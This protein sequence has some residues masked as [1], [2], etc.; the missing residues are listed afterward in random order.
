MTEQTDKQEIAEL[1]QVNAE[2]TESFQRCRAMLR[3]CRD[4]LAA[5]SNEPLEEGED[6]DTQIG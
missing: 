2:L 3:A 4:K 5:N 6:K 1:R